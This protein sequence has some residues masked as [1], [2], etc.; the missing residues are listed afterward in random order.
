LVKEANVALPAK[1]Q[2]KPFKPEEVSLGEVGKLEE[3]CFEKSLHR[4]AQDTQLKQVIASNEKL[5]VVARITE[6]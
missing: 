3:A 5:T 4:Q 2:V 1:K 6:R